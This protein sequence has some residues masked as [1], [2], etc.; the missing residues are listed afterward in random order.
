MSNKHGPAALEVYQLSSAGHA[1]ALILRIFSPKINS[2]SALCGL[3]F[4]SLLGKNPRSLTN[5]SS[6]TYPVL[7]HSKW[8]TY[9]LFVKG[10]WS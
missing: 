3:L 6:A 9:L 8:M 1:K 7:V 2:K 5:Y 10:G 4:A